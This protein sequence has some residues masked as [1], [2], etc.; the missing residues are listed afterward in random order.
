[1][2]ED[3]DDDKDGKMSFHEFRQIME[4]KQIAASKAG[5]YN[6]KETIL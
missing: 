4:I 6:F 3:G 2:V 1:M 5:K